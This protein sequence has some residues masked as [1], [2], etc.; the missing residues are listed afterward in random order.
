MKGKL[1]AR[2]GAK[3]N[4]NDSSDYETWGQLY[5]VTEVMSL[6][7]FSKITVHGRIHVSN[8]ST[9]NKYGVGATYNA[10]NGV[11]F[12]AGY[13]WTLGKAYNDV[14]NYVAKDAGFIIDA[15]KTISF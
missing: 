2:A 11:A 9:D 13:N 6:P 10:P 12:R 15:S 4:L 1:Y 7:G 8:K 5:G 14:A 3:I